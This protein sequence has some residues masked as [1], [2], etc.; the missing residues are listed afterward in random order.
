MA[1]ARVSKRKGKGRRK[2]DAGKQWFFNKTANDNA[3]L[4][5][6]RRIDHGC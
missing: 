5:M 2:N 6:L 1:T 3:L 4:Q